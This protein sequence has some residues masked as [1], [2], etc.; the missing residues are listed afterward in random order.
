MDGDAGSLVDGLLGM[1]RIMAGE[2]WIDKA[3]YTQVQGLLWMG[4]AG[5]FSHQL[6]HNISLVP[7]WYVSLV[8]GVVGSHA[9][10]Q[11]S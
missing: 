8:F 2:S 7:A 1:A 11:I 4:R 5:P 10:G 6:L 3:S 9:D